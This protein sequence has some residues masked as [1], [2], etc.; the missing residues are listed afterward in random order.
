MSNAVTEAPVA[1]QVWGK[2]F[3]INPL[4]AGTPAQKTWAKACGFVR[5]VEGW[6]GSGSFISGDGLFL[7]NNHVVPKELCQK[8]RCAGFQIVRNFS[9]NGDIEVYNN[10][11]PVLQLEDL[12]IALL[13]VELPPGEVV[14]H[15]NVAW[16]DSLDSNALGRS[17]ITIGHPAGAPQK[18]TPLVLDGYDLVH[19]YGHGPSI[20]GNSGGPVLDPVA[21][22][23]L[24]IVASLHFGNDTL[25]KNGVL[26]VSSEYVRTTAIL[27]AIAKAF[28]QVKGHGLSFD[29]IG[30][31]QAEGE[32]SPGRPNKM[33]A[34]IFEHLYL[35]ASNQTA[36]MDKL[37]GEL[38]KAHVPRISSTLKGLREVELRSGKTL[39]WTDPEKVIV[40]KLFNDW[41]TTGE[42]S[43]LW[44]RM[45]ND[46]SDLNACVQ[47]RGGKTILIDPLFCN[48]NGRDYIDGLLEYTDH[49]HQPES[50]SYASL[51][52][53]FILHR[54]D[55]GPALATNQI[56]KLQTILNLIHKKTNFIGSSFYAEGL[57][58]ALSRNPQLFGK[59]S[60]ALTY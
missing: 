22:E 43:V 39:T 21:G 30:K 48:L 31:S 12:D 50:E 26:G 53:W 4:S 57:S 20:W 3:V 55:A 34:Q 51:M 33:T 41:Q 37:L 14:P 46:T 15:L 58:L 29:A 59:D 17:L 36:G 47:T 60:F 49:L 42:I 10:I 32:N 11:R 5:S 38:N 56:S 24:G 8:N 54:L 40:H 44:T 2:D 25:N 1:V 7:T 9:E 18:I 16:S 52:L 35:G 45:T 27:D 28:P 19:L 6:Y 13:K 23:F